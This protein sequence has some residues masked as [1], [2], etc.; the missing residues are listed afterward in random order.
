MSDPFSAR[1]LELFRTYHTRDFRLAREGV[2][3]IPPTLS[4][5]TASGN[6]RPED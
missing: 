6:S 4:L 5:R 1:S 3:E 2:F